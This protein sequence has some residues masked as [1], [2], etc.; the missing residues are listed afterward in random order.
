MFLWDPD[1][2]FGFPDLHRIQKVYLRIRSTENKETR[3]LPA[4]S[5][6]R[7]DRENLIG[8]WQRHLFSLFSFCQLLVGHSLD[9][10]FCHVPLSNNYFRER[11]T[12]GLKREKS[13]KI[14]FS[15]FWASR[16]RNRILIQRNGSGSLFFLIKV[17]SGLQ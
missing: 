6:R 12:W 17:L 7:R 4:A 2:Y 14:Y 10:Y 3:G 11:G 13:H 8:T 9:I 1:P 5:K 15:C 16:V